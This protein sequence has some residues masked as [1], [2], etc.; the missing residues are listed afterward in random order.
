MPLP[1][2]LARQAV[3]MHFVL[4]CNIQ[5][6]SYSVTCLKTYIMIRVCEAQSTRAILINLVKPSY[7]SSSNSDELCSPYGAKPP[8]AYLRLR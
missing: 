2:C 4:P 3:F 8:H 5:P 7:F 6:C 1:C